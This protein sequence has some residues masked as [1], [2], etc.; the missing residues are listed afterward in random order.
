MKRISVIVE[1]EI[2][3]SLDFDEVERAL[4]QGLPS[5]RDLEGLRIRDRQIIVNGE[6]DEEQDPG[7]DPMSQRALGYLMHHAAEASR[8]KGGG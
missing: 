2:D 7:S 4:D 1:Y 5:G 8:R 6:T 3:T